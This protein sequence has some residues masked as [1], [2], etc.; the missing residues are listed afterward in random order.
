[1][2]SR[3]QSSIA[4]LA[5]LAL[6]FPSAPA[7]AA[8][9][10]DTPLLQSIGRPDARI[11]DLYAFVRGENLV[12]ILNTNPGIPPEAT[13]YLFPPDLKL[14]LHIDNHSEVDFSDPDDL[15]LFG[16][17]IVDPSKINA[18]I[19]FEV[20]FRANGTAKFQVKG[21]DGV[22]QDV[23]F[24]AGLRDD[25]FIRG[26]RA[27]RNIAAMVFE[28]PLVRV[29]GDSSTFLIWAT[30]K[31]PDVCSPVTEHAG[32]ALRSQFPENDSMNSLRPRQHASVLG[33]VPDVLIY[34]VALPAE[35]PNGRE[36]ID[37]VVDLVG[38]DRVLSSDA[39]F[40]D[41]NDLPFLDVFPYLSEPHLP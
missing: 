7:S 36:L 3:L 21:R 12:V 33:V 19:V 40:P 1:M 8:D 20:K 28:V 37:D 30:S 22:K 5:L 39:P 16:G 11:T 17:T 24:F 38:D 10:G 27:G 29:L 32:R 35:Y 25:P 4:L 2:K 31:L 9:H 26:P 14:R 13:D 15:D 23:L 34:D 41:E 18:D 6:V